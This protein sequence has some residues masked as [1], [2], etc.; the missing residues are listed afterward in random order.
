MWS[1]AMA[2]L[3]SMLSGATLSLGLVGSAAAQEVV[4][5]ADIEVPVLVIETPA[6]Q[7]HDEAESETDLTQ[8]VMS[9]AKRVQ[10]VQ[11][12]ASIVTVV[13]RSQIQVRGYKDFS[14]L[15]DDI[16]GFEGHRPTFYFDTSEAFARGNARTMLVLWNG[17][18][19]NSPQ[20]N[21]R[22]FGSYLPM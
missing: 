9:A 20:T 1:K 12:S 8:M 6:G 17:I 7:A 3:G 13:T 21:Q 19:L 4:G 22:A 5:S 2:K 15:L 14:S 10:T 16:P 18:P 11:E